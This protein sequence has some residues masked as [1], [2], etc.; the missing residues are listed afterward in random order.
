MLLS[1]LGRWTCALALVLAAPA[2]AAVGPP[3]GQVNDDKA[4]SVGIDPAKPAGVAD[5]VGGALIAGNLEIPWATFEQQTTPGQNIFVRA[6][7]GGAWV[8]E[9]FPAS[10]NIDT[11]KEAEGPSIDFAGPGR[12]VPW[13]G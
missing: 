8:T 11:T 6:F 9:G 12:T 7:K 2:S 1:R 4:A 3:A 10:L 5:V 13:V